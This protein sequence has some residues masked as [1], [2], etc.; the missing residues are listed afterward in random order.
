MLDYVL[1]G[2][3]EHHVTILQDQYCPP[4]LLPVGISMIS[5]CLKLDHYFLT[6]L[7]WNI[8]ASIRLYV[9]EFRSQPPWG[10]R[11]AAEVIGLD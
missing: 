2:L 3:S 11:K 1:R 7:S 8:R 5:H 10:L 9:L 4:C 6:T